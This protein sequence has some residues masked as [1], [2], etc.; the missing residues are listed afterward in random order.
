[1]ADK[2]LMQTDL[3]KIAIDI[4]NSVPK[5]N[6]DRVLPIVLVEKKDRSEESGFSRLDL[7]TDT[8]LGD[9]LSSEVFCY[10]DD[11]MMCAKT[12][13][14]HLELL[15]QVH[16]RIRSE[17]SILHSKMRRSCEY[18]WAWLRTIANFV[19]FSFSVFFWNDITK[20]KG[21]GTKSIIRKKYEKN[22]IHSFSFVAACVDKARDS[23]KPFVI[24]TDASTYESS[25]VLL[26]DGEDKQLHPIPS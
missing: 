1:M 15:K 23:S 22:D 4:E 2:E 9:L 24:R 8:A 25:A 13:E 3:L 7:L 19:G 16:D 17:R 12:K 6:F 5:N 11:V 14:R 18:F 21:F 20:G 26:R 10:I